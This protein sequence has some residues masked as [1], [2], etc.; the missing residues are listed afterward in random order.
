MAALSPL[1]TGCLFAKIPSHSCNQ[2]PPQDGW[3]RGGQWRR[4]QDSCRPLCSLGPV[5]RRSIGGILS[6]QP[7]KCTAKPR[8]GHAQPT[9][10]SSPC[11]VSTGGCAQPIAHGG[12]MPLR[13]MMSVTQHKVIT[14]LK[15][16]QGC[17]GN[18]LLL[19]T[20]LCVS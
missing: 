9:L 1:G 12:C 3:G 20:L 19:L 18:L 4:K 7:A 13:L 2:R 6:S 11:R 5:L 8:K 17:F 14:L 16:S 10:G 15:T